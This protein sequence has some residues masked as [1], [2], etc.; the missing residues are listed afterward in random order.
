M[1]KLYIFLI[2]GL[3]LT[4]YP[5]SQFEA[6]ENNGYTDYKFKLAEK[7]SYM[8]YLQKYSDK[9]S[10][11]DTVNIAGDDY[12]SKSGEVENKEDYTELTDKSSVTYEFT[13]ENSGMYNIE[14][15][16]C[17]IESK[18]LDIISSLK[19]DGQTP[20]DEA[21]NIT[22]KRV[23]TNKE[24]IKTVD[25]NDISPEQ[26]EVLGCNSTRLEDTERITGQP[27]EFYLEKG[28]HTIT[29]ESIQEPFGIESIAIEPLQ[30][31]KNYE[32]VQKQY[33]QENK[34]ETTGQ[35][36]TV[37]G[38]Q[39]TYK[40]TNRLSPGMDFS[41]SNVTPIDPY[42]QKANVIGG[43]EWGDPGDYIEWKIDV[44]ESGLYNI[45]IN[46]QQNF[47]RDLYSTRRL[48]ING[49]LP[50]AEA[51]D[52]EFLYSKNFNGYTL[53]D[54]EGQPYLFYFD[55]GENFLRLENVTGR[56]G[57]VVYELNLTNEMLNEVYRE[58]LMITGTTPDKYRSYNLEQNIDN[59]EYNLQALYDNLTLIETQIIDT[60]GG[61][62]DVISSI[63]KLTLQL[64]R[65]IDEPDNIAKEFSSF[66]SNIS[67]L[68]ATAKNMTDQKLTIDSIEITSPD[69]QPEDKSSS[70]ISTTLFGINRF[71]SSFTNDMDSTSGTTDGDGETI[72]VWITRGQDEM[73]S[74]RRIIDDY[75]T[76]Q[77][78]INVDLKLVAPTTLLPAVLSGEGPDVAMFLNQDIPVNYATRNTVEDL[79]TY[80]GYDQVA[81]RFFPSAITPFEYNGGVYGLP[82]EQKFPIM[83]YR[84][85]I[86][87]ELGLEVPTTWDELF[88]ILP[89]LNVNNMELMLEPT[90]ISTLGQTNP[91][92]IFTT[93][94]YQSGGTYYKNDDMES[95]LTEDQAID[96]FNTYT[97]FYTNYSV[98]VTADFSNRFKTGEAP[99]GIMD[100]TQYNQISIFAPELAGNIGVAPVPGTVGADGEINDH[101]ASLTNGMVMFKDSEHKDSSWEFMKWATS[102][103]AQEKFANELE[104]RVG[105]GG[106]WQSANVQALKN[107]SY[108]SDD[109]QQ[110]LVEQSKT[111]GVPQVPG[112]YITAREEENAFKSVVNE[113]ENPTEAMFEHVDSINKELSI[114]RKEFGLDYIDPEVSVDDE[115]NKE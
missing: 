23:W 100:Y 38:E 90:L 14:Y 34:K 94:L 81:S 42:H 80:P 68:P 29:I 18:G 102:A 5:V 45:T 112:G 77:T 48:L 111:V 62:G 16:Y 54:S 58:V 74:W 47:E 24:D 76:P 1:K 73:Q 39:A 103:D 15:N 89:I 4:T 8:N 2:L 55:Q 79:S 66:K 113:N 28:E 104:A 65:F 106:R 10:G 99:I 25:G 19:I 110:I 101:V 71:I 59:L 22:F 17:T 20:F 50:F 60:V 26:I 44:P 88:D 53:S 11:T 40:S 3:I 21:G 69:V 9:N 27:L 41:S 84:K 93:L 52:I 43:S 98:D 57:S 33:A 49:E 87:E 109:L 37:E 51:N 108:P 83:F 97:K 7:N 30:T 64:T 85:D 56:L 105:K 32:Q 35:A 95:A 6:S 13:I 70:F 72:E 63:D 92:L 114:K 61:K 75:F 82:E 96:A 86:F 36:I 12:V 78:G 115:E 91:N 31:V 67:A 46:A 107:S